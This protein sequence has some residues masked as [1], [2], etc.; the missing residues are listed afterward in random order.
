MKIFSTFLLFPLLAAVLLGACKKEGYYKNGGLQNGQLD[1][2][3]YQFLQSKPVYFDS[4]VAIIDA[5]GMKDMLSKN[6]VTFFAPHNYS[7]LKAMNLLNSVRYNKNQDS[8]H[9][10]DIPGEIWQKFLLR[11]T[12]TGKYLLKDIARRDI[13]MLQV[14]PGQYLESA[15]GYLMNLG[16]QFSDYSG[17]KD[18]GPRQVQIT[19]VGDF[20]NP[21][22]ITANVGSSDI[23]TTN[24]VV[25]VLDGNHG[26]GFNMMA[27]VTAVQDYFQ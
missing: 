13:R 8:L 5:A 27:F 16:V 9:I 25:Q 24:G 6:N 1:M 26:F 21:A 4:V 3:S 7:L 14:Y 11:Y 22:N 10:E 19:D 20:S 23:Q 12:F 17:T 18:V 2:N 15:G